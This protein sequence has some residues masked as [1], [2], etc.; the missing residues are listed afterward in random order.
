MVKAGYGLSWSFDGLYGLLMVKAGVWSKLIFKNG[1][2]MSQKGY[3]GL[4]M[5][6]QWSKMDFKYSKLI[7]WY[8]RLIS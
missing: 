5:V 2:T 3:N 1:L 7:F 6:F 4:L 8:S